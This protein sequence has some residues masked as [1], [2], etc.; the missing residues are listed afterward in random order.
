MKNVGS[1][2]R[3]SRQKE[4]FFSQLPIERLSPQKS[5]NLG[6]HFSVVWVMATVA[7][8]EVNRERS[9]DKGKNFQMHPAVFLPLSE[10]LP[11]QSKAER[12]LGLCNGQRAPGRGF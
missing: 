10:N 11:G 2:S 4:T 8:P 7:A 3:G 12:A 5:H 6:S 9:P 1:S